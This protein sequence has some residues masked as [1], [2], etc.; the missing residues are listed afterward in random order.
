MSSVDD[1][2]SSYSSTTNIALAYLASVT[3]GRKL[4]V[5]ARMTK[6]FALGSM[7]VVALAMATNATAAIFV[8]IRATTVHRGGFLQLVGNADRMP[9]YALPAARLPCARYGTCP[10]TPIHRTAPPK[11]PYRFLGYTPVARSDSIPTRPFAIRLPRALR[12]GRYKVFVWCKRCGD[13]LIIA[14]RD[15]SGETLRVVG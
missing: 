8:R 6:A 1:V 9:L 11:R 3:E 7:L 14:G 15:S 4:C 2:I 12:P 5:R 10:P 13:S